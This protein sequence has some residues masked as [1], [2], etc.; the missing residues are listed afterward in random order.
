MLLQNMSR[1]ELQKALFELEQALH[2]HLQ[3][4]RNLI[5]TLACRS[6]F[7]KHDVI[8]KAYEECRFGQWYYGDTTKIFADHP[9]FI[10]IGEA[11]RLMHQ[12]AAQLLLNLGESK[13]ILPS[14]YDHFSNS[15]ERLQLEIQA[16]RSELENTLFNR[17]QLTMAINRVSMLPILREQQELC[18]RDFQTCAL[19]MIDIDHFKKVNDKYGHI[20]G[21]KVLMM[22]AHYLM[23]SVR[24]YDKVFRY[25]GEEFLICMPHSDLQQARVMIERLR[26]G[27]EA[28]S[29]NVG[30]PKPVS[31]TVSCGMALL[32]AN[33][34]IEDSIDAADKAMY[35]AKTSGRN[36]IKLNKSDK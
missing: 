31:V 29:L 20:V 3:W 27:I 17:D 26:S 6:P 4:H 13:P 12:L 24:A 33:A 23:E 22:V 35:D 11:H 36:Q 30:A 7:D 14:D 28:M 5:R 34:A 25:G 18:R 9:G 32:D 19:A 1:E 16:L 8:P 2:N 10:A 15:L 21:D